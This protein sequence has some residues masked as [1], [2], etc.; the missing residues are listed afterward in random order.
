MIY[1]FIFQE[2][3]SYYADN[4]ISF[5]NIVIII[6]I[7]ISTLTVYIILD[8]FLNKFSNYIIYIIKY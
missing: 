6:I 4:L 7:T 2:S 1:I 8:L 3:N 5:H